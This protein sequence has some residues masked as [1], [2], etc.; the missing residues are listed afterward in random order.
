MKHRF[1]IDAADNRYRALNGA[2]VLPFG[3]FQWKRSNGDIFFKDWHQIAEFAT[4]ADA[5]KHYMEI[6]ILPEYLE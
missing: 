4:K 5:Y 1:K 6:Q 3:L 2:D